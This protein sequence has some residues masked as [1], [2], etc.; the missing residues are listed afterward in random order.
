VPDFC[1]ELGLHTAK[2]RALFYEIYGFWLGDGSLLQEF[3]VTFSH[4]EQ[5]W[6]EESL[7][8]LE[9]PY[10]KS[11]PSQTGQVTISIQSDAWN[12]VFAAEYQHMYRS[13]AEAAVAPVDAEGR[14][15]DT[16]STA[17]GS[18]M[19][20]ESAKWFACWVWRLGAASLRRVLT[21]LCRADGDSTK[22]RCIWTSSARF[23][24]EIQ[25]VC[26][27]AGYTAHF[28]CASK[29][30]DAGWAVSFAEPDG[31]PAGE[32]ACK[33]NLFKARGEIRTRQYTGRVWCFTMPSGFIWVRRVAKDEHGVVIKA[34]R[35]LITGNCHQHR[36]LHRDLKPQNLLINRKG[37]L[38]LADF[39]L[40]RAFG[41]PVRSYSHEVVT[42]WY[43]APDVLMGSR[44]YSQSIDLWSCGTIFAEMATGR[45]LFPGTNVQ[46]QLVRIFKVMGTPSEETWPGVSALPE[47][48]AN[49]PPY[50]PLPVEAIIPN[51][52]PAGYDLFAQMCA[53]QPEL[54]ITCEDA[55]KHD[56]FRD[57]QLPDGI[58]P[59]TDEP[60]KPAGG[61]MMAKRANSTSVG[62][63]Y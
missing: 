15:F 42:L 5:A 57:V 4:V 62:E 44:K 21:G 47:Y 3:A 46:D 28:R 55:L 13:A 14:A 27:M 29:A 7:T 32:N 59:F 41:I 16:V 12:R 45:P 43:R 24:D 35:P 52:E 40:A 61:F 19:Q 8:A 34:S 48:N 50:P 1:N 2:Q 9:V 53:Y 36:V 49:M 23:R 26:L 51:L 18:Y 10:I 38:K 25:R 60:K 33:P 39:G 30:R 56:Y 11:D 6:L 17:K 54:R 63:M 58:W 37:E 20:P 31:S 22:S